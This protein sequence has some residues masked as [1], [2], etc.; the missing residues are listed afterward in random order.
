[1]SGF[2]VPRDEG[3]EASS[4]TRE[5]FQHATRAWKLR[6]VSEGTRDAVLLGPGTRDTGYPREPRRGLRD[7][8]DATGYEETKYFLICS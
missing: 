4:S 7:T 5:F 1:M 2:S 3:F 8:R 6:R